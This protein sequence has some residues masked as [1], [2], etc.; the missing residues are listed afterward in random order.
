M[1][2]SSP[3]LTPSEPD[4]GR[5][6][7]V[8]FLPSLIPQGGL[9]GGGGVAVVIDQLRASSTMVRALAAGAE[10]LIPC[11]ETDEALRLRDQLVQGGTPRDRVRTGGERGG[12][13]IPG[14]DLDNS[15]LE[16]TPDSVGGRT[17][18][19][20]TTNGTLAIAAAKRVGGAERILVGCLN[21]LSAVVRAVLGASQVHLVCA[22]TRGEVSQEDV[23][24]AGAMAAMLLKSG[25]SPTRDDQVRIA[26]EL[27]RGASEREGGV[28]DLMRGSW[29]GRNL[30][31]LGFDRDIVD[32]SVVDS[33]SIVPE[34][35]AD[36][37]LRAAAN[38]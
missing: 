30:T 36:G 15:P 11:L 23:G 5:V 29:G 22:G 14:F 18:V 26:A 6:V 19:F 21:N 2:T 24:C 38:R 12:V 10:R 25:F 34:L 27:W 28:L 1:S 33:Q 13:R 8:Y 7:G 32:T 17:V 3:P 35:C 31:R 4:S 37:S 20:T 16:Y 9:R